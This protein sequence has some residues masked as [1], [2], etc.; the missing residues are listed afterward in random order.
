MDNF[1]LLK[2]GNMSHKD[3][4]ARDLCMAIE[5][6]G[7]IRDYEIESIF[8]DIKNGMFKNEIEEVLCC[9]KKHRPD[10]CLVIIEIINYKK[11]G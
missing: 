3:L 10:S 5:N 8:Y 1:I 4:S 7:N 9:L 2:G 11:G 6:V